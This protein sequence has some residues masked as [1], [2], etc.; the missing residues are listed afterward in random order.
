MAKRTPWFHY[1]VS[2]VIN[3]STWSIVSLQTFKVSPIYQR[4][5]NAAWFCNKANRRIPNRVSKFVPGR[6]T[7]ILPRLVVFF[8]SVL[9]NFAY[10]F[11]GRVSSM[12]PMFLLTL[13]SGILYSLAVLWNNGCHSQNHPAHSD[14]TEHRDA[15]GGWPGNSSKGRADQQC[16]V[17]AATVSVSRAAV[18]VALRQLSVYPCIPLFKTIA[19][20]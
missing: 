19:V 7:D 9:L 5:V 11:Q 1:F 3:R 15:M 20:R 4:V 6:T 10:C 16:R 2:V 17:R 12:S 18:S 14:A 8:N 13:G